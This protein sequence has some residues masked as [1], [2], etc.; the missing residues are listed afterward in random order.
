MCQ[1]L[2]PCSSVPHSIVLQPY[3][4]TTESVLPSVYSTYMYQQDG[5]I[6]YLFT[7][8]KARSAFYYNDYSLIIEAFH[9][10]R[11]PE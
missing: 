10:L 4:S 1:C 8:C 5:Y 3:R 7:N 11:E 2:A 9:F 6:C